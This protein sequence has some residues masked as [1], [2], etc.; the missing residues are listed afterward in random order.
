[1][2]RD[3]KHEM[4]DNP[5][6]NYWQ[7]IDNPKSPPGSA[8]DEFPQEHASEF[9]DSSLVNKSRRDFL[10]ILGFAFGAVP[11]VSSCHRM[12]VKK[13]LAYLNKEERVTPGIANWYATTC[14]GCSASCGLLVKTREGRPIKIE[15]NPEN[16]FSRGGVCAVGQAMVLG[17]YDSYRYLKP[18][19][20][21]SDV[22]LEEVDREVIKRLTEIR[23]SRGRV[24]LV[25]GE[26]RSPTTLKVIGEF[27]SRAK[28]DHFI[29]EPVSL[30]PIAR[31]H[32]QT[33]GQAALPRYHLDQADL[34]VSFS[35][36]FLGTWYSPIEFSKQ[37]ASRRAPDPETSMLRHIQVEG[38]MSLTAS[39]ADVRISVTPSREA[40]LL[41]VLA[42]HVAE[43]AGANAGASLLKATFGKELA[44][45]ELD[46][47]AQ[48]IARELWAAKGRALVLSG[49]QDPGQQILVNAINH[50]LGAYGK[51]IQ[52]SASRAALSDPDRFELLLSDL[53]REKYQA[54]ILWGTN[55]VYSHPGFPRLVEG[56]KKAATVIHL[57]EAPNETSTFTSTSTMTKIV[58]PTHH[59]LESWNDHDLGEGW[60]GITQPVIQPL[61]QT[62]MAQESLMKWMGMSISYPDYLEAN[63][64][65]NFFHVQKKHASPQSFWT[66]SLHD[67]IAKV[68]GE[69]LSLSGFRADSL[70]GVSA[71]ELG[72]A[73]ELRIYQKVSLRDGRFAN[74]PWLQELPDPITKV[75]WDNYAQLSPK[76]SKSLGVKTGDLV[77]IT[78]GSIPLVLP[79]LIQP[80]QNDNLVSIA[81]GYGHLI[82]GKT[83][84]NVGQ[85]AFI[86][87]DARGVLDSTSVTVVKE[88]GRQ[89]LST[90]QMHHRMEGRD[91]VRETTFARFKNNPSAGN[92][93]Q[94]KNPTMWSEHPK[95]QHSWAMTID[96]SRCNGCSACLVSCQAENNVPV[97][98]KDEVFR[99]REMHWIRIDRYYEGDESNPRVV[100]QPMTCHHC[101]NAPCE[102]VCPVLA[103]VH[104]SDGINQQVYNRCVGTR[105][106]ANNCPYKVRRFNWFDYPH[107]DNWKKAIYSDDN[108]WRNMALNPDVVVRSRGVMEKCSLCIHR[109][110]DAKLRA[111]KEGRPLADGEIRLACQQSCPTDA[112]IFGDLNDPASRV[113]L[114]LKDPRHY[115]VLHE[116]NVE[117]RLRYLTKV[118]N[119]T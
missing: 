24:A 53:G 61:R 49:S 70:R 59:F 56:L 54:V 83:G 26:I 102:T 99:Q 95:D 107:E 109:I 66:T 48:D 118:R 11:L 47:T 89:E 29:Y 106:C 72:K 10:G 30:F 93:V 43:M 119:Q 82:S 101:E 17:L 80:G 9:F 92:P 62:R 84:K 103:T 13:A 51:T 105:Y 87:I 112:I 76:A 33:H 46:K 65:K 78:K 2:G 44:A 96:L 23:S 25:T 34:V 52:L 55:P 37:Y 18:Q 117:P 1:M 8:S 60:L 94:E 50:W 71:P 79:A 77:R 74:N 88:G 73:M 32:L 38:S 6:R 97:V 39:N 111:K 20:G 35:A 21:I 75:T 15:G 41:G 27:I 110:Q 5:E 90:T 19:V 108:D 3:E 40:W 28:A 116:I 64:K 100:H 98:G 91:I 4:T 85:N 16:P 58:C 63:W 7:D 67:G 36:D 114:S 31:A 45:E 22:S 68:S 104:S 113:S 86:F 69:P 42:R 12:P 14:G 115:R 57:A 81:M